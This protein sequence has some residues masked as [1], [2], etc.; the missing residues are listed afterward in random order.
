[1]SIFPT[2]Q[3]A[4]DDDPRL[5]TSGRK[6][7]VD[8]ADIPDEA[9]PKEVAEP[10]HKPA[11]V[12]TNTAPLPNENAAQSKAN[13]GDTPVDAKN[14]KPAN[15]PAPE[16]VKAAAPTV[17]TPLE[18]APAAVKGTAPAVEQGAGP[19]Q[20]ASALSP[21]IPQ[22]PASY[23]DLPKGQAIRLSYEDR[24]ISEVDSGRVVNSVT[25]IADE[26][27]FKKE[28]EDHLAIHQEKRAEN[29]PE[30]I[31]VPEVWPKFM[32]FPRKKD[33]D[34]IRY[35]EEQGGL[36]DEVKEEF[37]ANFAKQSELMQARA[38]QLD[39]W[40]MEENE[41][42]MAQEK[43]IKLIFKPLVK[44]ELKLIEKNR[45]KAEK[46]NAASI[47]KGKGIKIAEDPFKDIKWATLLDPHASPDDPRFTNVGRWGHN[48]VELIDGGKLFANDEGMHVPFGDDGS[49]M[50]GEMA[51]QEAIERGWT[52]IN[53]S[54]SEEFIEGARK[55]ALAAGLGA[56]LTTQYGFSKSARP[57]FIM[58]NPPKLAGF[59]TE[60]EK[61]QD[62]H[63]ELMS[64]K[65]KEGAPE[66][67]RRPLQAP[68]KGGAEV[69]KERTSETAEE[70]KADSISDP[71]DEDP[72]DDEALRKLREREAAE[73][74]L[75]ENA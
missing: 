27:A 22:V 42:I 62:A 38:A 9:L 70:P 17:E 25:Q 44:R 34:A 21:Y 29:L 63:R 20:T 73:Q 32:K 4:E 13:K 7:D 1:M 36:T 23:F 57:E 69:A 3:T 56:K 16:V 14:D 61:T 43:R 71:F 52:S 47:K 54:G 37:N 31:E 64:D 68:G 74:G 60:A 12:A 66:G 15:K 58:P 46:V 53:I 45:A 72:K 50:A 6:E 26:E 40:I 30:W 65:G 18:P 28:A 2:F 67:Q 11:P 59:R 33:L 49:T 10:E 5:D 41:Q 75:P 51:V 48:C 35:A 8:V 24:H 19:V 39:A 55:A